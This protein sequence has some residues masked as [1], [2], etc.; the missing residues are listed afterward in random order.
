MTEKQQIS[1]DQAAAILGV[2]KRRVQQIEQEKNPPPRKPRQPYDAREFGKWLRAKWLD[3]VGVNSDGVA[4]DY[5]LERA[6]LTYHQANNEELKEREARA[7]LVSSDDV[8]RKWLDM[9]SAMRAK[10]LNLPGRVA[11]TALAATTLREVEDYVREEIH[12][13]LD[14]LG[15]RIAGQAA[16]A[17]EIEG[18]RAKRGASAAAATAADR[19]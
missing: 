18:T 9:T 12:R 8:L 16:A 2:T 11:S 14:E 17:E 5:Q 4:Y 15:D 7:E 19:Q 1:L 13:A 6:R 10:L 3:E